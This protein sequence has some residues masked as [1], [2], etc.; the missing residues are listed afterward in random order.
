M[1]NRMDRKNRGISPVILILIIAVI[2]VAIMI[3]AP[4]IISI[5]SRH[6]LS[7]N[8]ANAR[9]ARTLASNQYHQDVADGDVSYQT[10]EDGEEVLEGYYWYDSTEQ[11]IVSFNQMKGD[12]E[13][14]TDISSWEISSFDM[15][16]DDKHYTL[17]TDVYRYWVVTFNR[18]GEPEIMVSVKKG[19]LSTAEE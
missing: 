2:V 14:S 13:L 4:Y 10:N 17:G 18:K 16:I 7:V 12:A 3:V 8:Q 1:M 19:D 15:T 11:K 9:Q 5:P 6:R